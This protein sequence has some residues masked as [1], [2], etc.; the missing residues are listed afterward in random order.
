MKAKVESAAV[1]AVLVVCVGV[2]FAE[3]HTHH[4]RKKVLVS[5]PTPT[6]TV[7]PSPTPTPTNTPRKIHTPED[8]AAL[9]RQRI[10]DFNRS[11]SSRLISRSFDDADYSK[12][13]GQASRIFIAPSQGLT[14]D[15]VL[16]RAGEMPQSRSP[17]FSK[18]NVAKLAVSGLRQAWNSIKCW[19]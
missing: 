11:Y 12:F 4:R 18:M 8:I 16:I 13:L 10:N 6:A 2:T 1:L 7:S 15:L 19:P 14:S 3:P 17:A 9:Q 5:T